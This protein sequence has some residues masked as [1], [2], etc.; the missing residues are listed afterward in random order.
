MSLV[1]FRKV[2]HCCHHSSFSEKGHQ[3]R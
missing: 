3:L 2:G 1:M